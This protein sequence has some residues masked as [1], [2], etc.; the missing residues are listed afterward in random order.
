[1][2]ERDYLRRLPR[3]HYCGRAAV[4]WSMTIAGRS[5]G[6]L[7]DLFHARFREA[8]LHAMH[9]EALLCPAYVL[10]P[11]HMHVLWMGM[12]ERSA[13]LEAMRI[14]RGALNEHLAADG[15]TLQK[16]AHDRVLRESERASEALRSTMHYVFENPVRGGLVSRAEDWKWSGALACGYPDMNWRDGTFW[17]R[18][19]KIHS[20]A[21]ELDP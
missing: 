10:M 5:T 7:S 11:D 8:L 14:L 3:E 9:R 4:L 12:T 18:W 17:D 6:W 16:Q 20:I 15:F 1:M 21:S 2:P 19:W 13:Q